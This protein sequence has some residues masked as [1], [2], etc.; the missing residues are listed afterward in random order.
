MKPDLNLVD[1]VY[2]HL[3]MSRKEVAILADAL[4]HIRG[5]GCENYLANIGESSFGHC[6]RVRP[7]GKYAEFT[8]ESWCNSCI[9]HEALEKVGR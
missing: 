9:A 5:A 1:G 6:I 4:E 3:D 8:A 7:N 2:W